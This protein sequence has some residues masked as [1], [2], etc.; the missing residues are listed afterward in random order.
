MKFVA[1]DTEIIN[2]DEVRRI[3]RKDKRLNIEFKDKTTA[4][5]EEY[6][7]KEYCIEAYFDLVAEL[8]AVRT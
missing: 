6:T 2:M 4:I 3:W 5:L 1:S 8:R 7:T